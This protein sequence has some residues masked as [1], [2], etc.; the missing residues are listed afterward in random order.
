MRL[1]LFTL[2]I[3]VRS[4]GLKF[5]SFEDFQNLNFVGRY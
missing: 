4:E 2:V 5:V 1:G 3:S